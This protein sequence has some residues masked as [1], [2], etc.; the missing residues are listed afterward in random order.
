MCFKED[1]CSGA[2][3]FHQKTCPVYRDS[4]GG[5]RGIWTEVGPIGE[6]DWPTGGVGLRTGSSTGSERQRTDESRRHLF[7]IL[8]SL[9]ARLHMHIYR[10]V[11]EMTAA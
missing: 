6:R 11:T 7:A 10:A 3:G 1:K 2:A 4:M 8:M 5:S 9:W